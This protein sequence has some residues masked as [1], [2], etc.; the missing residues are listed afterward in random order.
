MKR[1]FRWARGC[2]RSNPR[3]VLGASAP[4]RL[5][6]LAAALA[7]LAYVVPAAAG[8][9]VLATE[10]D[11]FGPPASGKVWFTTPT[12]A[13]SGN[14]CLRDATF[15]NIP[16][17][18]PDVTF[19]T[20]LINFSSYG[21]YQNTGNATQD[22]TIGSYLT[23]LGAVNPATIA[24]SGLTNTN[25]GGVAS[26][27]TPLISCANNTCTWLTFM[28]ITGQ[29]WLDKGDVISIAHDDGVSLTI[30]GHLLPGF[31]AINA[32]GVVESYMWNGS[33]GV[34]TLDL[35]YSE[36]HSPP[37]YLEFAVP[38]PASMSLLGAALLGLGMIRRLRRQ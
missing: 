29:I 4:L 23:S 5:M 31:T 2:G 18:T 27:G 21:F 22:F 16:A 11:R 36:G 32:P 38:E 34:A 33:T 28:E 3:F 35:V 24:Y 25:L 37:A 19:S 7:I 10:L 15:A 6:I 12:P 14:C 26:S 30:N 8:P 9:Y 1:A 13:T 17:A 20:S